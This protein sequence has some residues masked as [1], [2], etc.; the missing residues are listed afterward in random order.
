MEDRT[1]Q[2]QY[3]NNI[4]INKSN[5]LIATMGAGK[6]WILKCIIDKYF[7][8]KR[9][10]I[11]TNRRNLTLQLAKSFDQHTFILSGKS[12]DESHNIHL[13]TTQTFAKRSH[14]L[15]DYDMVC[16]DEI[17]ETYNTKVVKQIRELSC[18]R[19]YMT[20]T[21]INSKGSFL[22]EFDNEL[23]F[24]T[25]QQMIDGGYL[26]PTRFLSRANLLS[27]ESSMSVRNGDYVEADIERVIQKQ[28]L[29]K[30]L[31]K[32]NLHYKWSTEHKCILY[33]NS[34]NIAQQVVDTM[35]EPDNIRVVHSKLSKQEL[36]SVTEWF[37][38]C[39]NG[40]LVNVRMYTTGTD[41]PSCD[42]IINLNATKIISLYLQSIWRASRYLPGKTATVVDY[43]GNLHKI[44]PYFN[45]WHKKKPTCREECSKITDR[46]QRYFCEASCVS[47]PPM[48]NCTGQLPYSLV[49]NPYVSNF[50]VISG[51]P[52]GEMIPAHKMQF[53]STESLEHI[54]KRTTCSCGC[55]TE[56]TIKSL[57][58]PSDMIELYAE[59]QPPQCTVTVIYDNSVKRAIALFDDLNRNIK[60]FEFDS[61]KQL[62]A[63]ALIYFKQSKFLL[64][65]NV[66]MP[67]LAN[68][69]IDRELNH[70][71]P[72]IDW[73]SKTAN[74]G[75]IRKLLKLKLTHIVE[76]LGMKPG[77]VFYK[78]KAITKPNERKVWNFLNS[79]N[80]D[81]TNFFKFFK[82]YEDN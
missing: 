29:I 20:G 11:I 50:T 70:F 4:Q 54:I 15:S 65:S 80:I 33:V 40:I 16:V 69:T 81:R 17:H 75:F 49:D 57:T 32:D 14:N 6:T 7:S 53:S 19:I 31:T 48:C 44:S 42:T 62:F 27:D 79:Q 58:A 5:I 21:P 25:I 68:V 26:A 56:Y 60:V 3:V 34:I 37:E 46:M 10:L 77:V 22:G 67:Q 9:V 76:F 59:D 73:S 55:V 47:E 74:A 13:A 38:N 63:D 43:S 36:T 8:N 64:I 39:T 1:Y 66:P 18:T 24:T 28:D 52:C 82:S 35:N 51:E 2:Q 30:W 23:E 71:I 78:M 72:L 12:H 45:E 61:S 41:I